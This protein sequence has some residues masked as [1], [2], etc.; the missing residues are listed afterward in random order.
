MDLRERIALRSRDA[1]WVA[2][3][4]GVLLVVL[5]GR[6]F[7]VSDDE[8][9]NLRIHERSASR[10]HWRG[11]PK[12]PLHATVD[13]VTSDYLPT[14]VAER[15]AQVEVLLNV[16][17]RGVAELRACVA[18]RSLDKLALQRSSSGVQGAPRLLAEL[19]SAFTRNEE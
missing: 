13:I 10:V 6:L 15:R 12:W 17:V 11:S 8:A 3:V 19:E 14:F 18:A 9:G 1:R 2:A 4:L 16:L 5:G 7:E